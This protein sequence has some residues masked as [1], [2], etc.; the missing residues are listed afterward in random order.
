[1]KTNA[2]LWIKWTHQRHQNALAPKRSTF[3]EDNK[4]KCNSLVIYLKQA[5]FRVIDRH[6][7]LCDLIKVSS[8]CDKN[9]FYVKLS[10][11]GQKLS[12]N[13][14]SWNELL[15]K[16]SGN[17]FER[18]SKQSLRHKNKQNS[19]RKSCFLWN[20]EKN[21]MKLR[22]IGAKISSNFNIWRIFAQ[23]FE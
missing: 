2:Q 14:K 12:K 5:N 10:Q 7:F 1:M 9:C 20:F 19:S 16:I 11:N 8:F 18:S 4:S 17:A 13:A 22:E 3:Y 21:F 6:W 23:K 15:N